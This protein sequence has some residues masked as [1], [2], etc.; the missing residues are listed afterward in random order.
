MITL[1]EFSKAFDFENDFYLSCDSSRLGKFVAHYELFKMSADVPGDV[2]ECG[3]FK[4]VSFVRFAVFRELLGRNQAQLLKK[5]MIG[6]DAFGFFPDTQ[7][8]PDQA[9]R[10]KFIDQAG[11]RGID[12]E[13]LMDVLKHK[14]VDH[15]VELIKGDICQTLP[16]YV[17]ENPDLKL[18]FLH[19]DADIYEP[20]KVILEQLY[21]KLSRGGVLVL[22]DYERWQGETLAFQEYFKRE[23]GSVPS[24]NR[25]PFAKTPVYLIK[26]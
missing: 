22:D 9:H 15:N 20:S 23:Y 4:G 10:Q 26:E 3:L 5:K 6:F 21:P 18:S 17:E 25:F 7:F 13:Q 11:E 1:P 14:K 19:M 8:G 24:V 12:P 2:L 16:R